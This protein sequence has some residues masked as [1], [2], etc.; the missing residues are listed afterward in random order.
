MDYRKYAL[1]K[2]Y[3]RIAMWNAFAGNEAYLACS[4][5]QQLNVTNQ[6]KRIEEEI[7]ELKEHVTKTDYP[8]ERERLVAILDDF[9]DIFVT[10]A[11]HD[12]MVKEAKGCGVYAQSETDYIN[13]LLMTDDF[14]T[15]ANE[16]TVENAIK[17]TSQIALTTKFKKFDLVGAVECV[18]D[19]NF[20]KFIP[21]GAKVWLEETKQLYKDEDIYITTG[22]VYH[23]V[24]RKGDNKI[25]K[26]SGFT[27]PDLNKYVHV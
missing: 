14:A 12:Y 1:L 4:K 9:A 2:Q 15:I 20:S 18:M 24:R 19:V 8:S 23:S 25:L 3:D 5:T 26:P 7:N 13:N 22:E 16:I 21:V 6:R 17:I 27:P 10:G 11:Y